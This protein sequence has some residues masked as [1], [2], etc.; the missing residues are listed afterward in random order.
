MLRGHDNFCKQ[1]P[2]HL[3][4]LHFRAMVS[5]HVHLYSTA[6]VCLARM[7]VQAITYGMWGDVIAEC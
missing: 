6:G 4:K 1:S 2:A 7:R 5:F 3:M